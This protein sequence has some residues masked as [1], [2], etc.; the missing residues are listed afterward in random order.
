MADATMPPFIY[1]GSRVSSAE[2]LVSLMPDHSHYVEPFA[3]SLSVLFRKT[4]APMETVNDLDGLLMTFWRVLRDDFEELERV[5]ALTPTGREEYARAQ[6]S[7]HEPGL[8][9]IERAR[10]VFVVFTQGRAGTLRNT[11]WRHFVKGGGPSG[12][13]DRVSTYLGRFAPAAQR[14]RN[15]GLECRDALDVVEAY[16]AYSDNLIYADPPALRDKDASP[17]Y[18]HEMRSRRAHGDLA[19][20]LKACKATVIVSGFSGALYDSLYRDWDRMTITGAGEPHPEVA[21][22]NRPWPGTLELSW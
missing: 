1:A 8:S 2:K 7:L 5:C 6:R 9:D 10:R 13:P 20:A 19:D 4:R 3:G 17:L 16:G 15:V 22:S 11:G 12:I 21:W 18:S 14:L